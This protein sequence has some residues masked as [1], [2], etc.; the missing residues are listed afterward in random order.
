MSLLQ[1]MADLQGLRD[2]LP[3]PDAALVDLLLS[4]VSAWSTDDTSVQ[5]LLSDLDRIL[6]NVWF[7]TNERHAQAVLIL[8][9]LHD[10]VAN[11]GGI[12]N[13]LKTSGYSSTDE[14]T[15]VAIFALL[16]PSRSR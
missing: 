12:R 8:A 10:S 4:R 3:S 13:L 16:R 6:G 7:S 15:F 5:T 2:H 11:L 1:A 9:R 14:L